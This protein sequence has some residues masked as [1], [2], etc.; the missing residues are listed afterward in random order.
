MEE[1]HNET[2]QERA[3]LVGLNADCFTKEQTATDQTLEEL[4]ALLETAG[5]FC[6]GKILQNRHAHCHQ[7][8]GHAHN[9]A[10]ELLCYSCLLCTRL[11]AP[12]IR[13]S[14]WRDQ[15]HLQKI[16]PDLQQDVSVVYILHRIVRHKFSRYRRNCNIKN[17]GYNGLPVLLYLVFHSRSSFSGIHL[18][19][20]SSHRWKEMLS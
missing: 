16:V 18:Q 12:A 7:G 5:G 20:I 8:R 1:L 3:V 6:T 9:S 2:Q 10:K 11:S 15:Q 14:K 13:E 19:I 17:H 4:E